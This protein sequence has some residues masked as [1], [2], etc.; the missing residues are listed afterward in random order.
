[1]IYKCSKCGKILTEFDVNFSKNL[2]GS[3][4]E[5]NHKCANCLGNIN[6]LKEMRKPSLLK[7]ILPYLALLLYIFMANNK[8]LDKRNEN[9]ILYAILSIV[10]LIV[11]IGLICFCIYDFKNLRSESY[12]ESYLK[13]TYDSSSDSLVTVSST[14]T[15]GDDF[16]SEH[17]LLFLSYP[18]W[19][20]FVYIYRLIKFYVVRNKYFSRKLL[21]VY[22]KTLR[23]TEEFI[24]PI[25][26]K[27]TY[28]GKMNKYHELKGHIETKYAYLN[29]NTI[30]EEKIK[31]LKKPT[32]N[33][34]STKQT[35]KL[36]FINGFY[37]FI[38]NSTT[39]KILL[40]NY[41]IYLTDEQEIENL[42]KMVDRYIEIDYYYV[43]MEESN[44]IEKMLYNFFNN[45]A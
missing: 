11:Y 19:G 8:L 43:F 24:I 6:A 41:A 9:Y 29:N 17:I 23:T 13:T 7:Y 38:K 27:S 34:Q 15:T 36:I 22:R 20:I 5:E 44:N 2:T 39:R 10:C 4:D 30:I 33:I 1:M 12:E 32:I 28:Q 21:R 42:F 16:S 45:E 26:T 40:N 14:R 37:Y 18:A 25:E 31:K 3:F 35:Y